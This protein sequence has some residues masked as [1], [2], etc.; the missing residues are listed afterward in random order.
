MVSYN[1]N[2]NDDDD[3]DNDS[4]VVVVVAVMFDDD[5]NDDIIIIIIIHMTFEFCLVRIFFSIYHYSFIFLNSKFFLMVDSF[6]R[7]LINS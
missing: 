6:F 1:N 4:N 5:N 7:F 3:R 2:N